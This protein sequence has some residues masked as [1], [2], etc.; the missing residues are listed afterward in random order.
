VEPNEADVL[1]GR[2]RAIRSHT[3]NQLYITLIQQQKSHY[4]E[5]A[6]GSKLDIVRGVVEAIR[7]QHGRF[8]QKHDKYWMDIGDPKAMTKTAQ[9]FRDLRAEDTT[10]TTTTILQTTTTSSDNPQCVLAG[11]GKKKKKI[12]MAFNKPTGRLVF[13]VNRFKNGSVIKAKQRPEETSDSSSSSGSSASEGGVTKQED[14]SSEDSDGSDR[15][16]EEEEESS[17]SSSD[18]DGDVSETETEDSF[19]MYHGGNSTHHI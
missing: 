9:A 4:S 19:P 13:M 10:T 5:A 16:A 11:G 17:E 12:S 3:G 15:K 1:C 18:D 7:D 2:G 14:S 6:K 8:L